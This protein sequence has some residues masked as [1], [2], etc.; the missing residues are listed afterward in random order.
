[1]VGITL[2]EM[3]S[4]QLQINLAIGDN[5]IFFAFL[6]LYNYTEVC[7]QLICKEKCCLL[8]SEINVGELATVEMKIMLHTV[9]QC[10]SADL[11]H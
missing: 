2:G 10:S 5:V 7:M 3:T 8:H 11:P 1:M 6:Q 4:N 9:C